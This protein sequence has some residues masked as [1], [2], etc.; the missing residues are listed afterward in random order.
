[1][2]Y[3]SWS[4]I[5]VYLVWRYL[6]C[7]M[8]YRA[9]QNVMRDTVRAGLQWTVSFL[10]SSSRTISNIPHW[11]ST[12]L[13]WPHLILIKTLGMRH[14]SCV[15]WFGGF[16]FLVKKIE[17]QILSTLSK[18]T[19][20]ANGKWQNK[21]YNMIPELTSGIMKGHCNLQVCRLV[22]MLRRF[23]HIPFGWLGFI[24]W[25]PLLFLVSFPRGSGSGKWVWGSSWVLEILK[26]KTLPQCHSHICFLKDK[27]RYITRWEGRL[28]GKGGLRRRLFHVRDFLFFFSLPALRR[29]RHLRY[30]PH[31]RLCRKHLCPGCFIH[32]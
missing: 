25:N 26:A 16:N 10:H 21:F 3:Q 27:R 29:H 5:R 12:T 2:G 14:G 23:V 18:I 1:M 8:S 6:A 17:G 24:R 31:K 11:L 30:L 19:Q 7:S 32:G 20:L 9:F 22:S 4:I 15:F 13:R 28:P